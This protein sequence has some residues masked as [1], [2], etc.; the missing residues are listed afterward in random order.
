MENQHTPLELLWEV[1]PAWNF[2]EEYRFA[3]AAFVR[4]HRNLSKYLK[5]F[6]D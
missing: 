2:D 5:I 3:E 4:L 1:K 6:H